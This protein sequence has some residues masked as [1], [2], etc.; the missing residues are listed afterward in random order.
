MQKNPVV[1]LKDAL[2]AMK[3]ENYKGGIHLWHTHCARGKSMNKNDLS[4]HSTYSPL[5]VKSKDFS[6]LPSAKVQFIEPMYALPGQTLPQ[7]Q[8]WLYEAKFDG[9]R[10]LARRNSTTVT[11]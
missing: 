10:C 1:A 11:L 9:H 4:M 3:N 6:A 5:L 7:G 8:E 2:Q